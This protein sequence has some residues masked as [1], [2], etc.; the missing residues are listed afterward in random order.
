MRHIMELQYS[1]SV[2]NCNKQSC[3]RTNMQ[4]LLQIFVG[5]A[6]N[7]TW[8]VGNNLQVHPLII[9]AVSPQSSLNLLITDVKHF[10]LKVLTETPV[11]DLEDY[12]TLSQLS[13]LIMLFY[14]NL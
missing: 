7:T 3:R 4:L 11:N 1:C 2:Y 14:N 6:V 10:H 5:T 8:M 12:A 9:A 13:L